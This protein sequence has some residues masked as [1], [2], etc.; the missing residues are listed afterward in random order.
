MNTPGTPLFVA[1]I[2]NDIWALNVI[3][4]VHNNSP[5]ETINTMVLAQYPNASNL[6]VVAR[7]LTVPPYAYFQNGKSVFI[8]MAGASTFQAALTAIFSDFQIGNQQ[9][10]INSV[11]PAA[12]LAMQSMIDQGLSNLL[13]G[14]ASGTFYGYS[15][16]GAAM[17]AFAQN[18]AASGNTIPISV[19]TYG[20]PKPFYTSFNGSLGITYTNWEN[21][22]DP[23][24][25]FPPN[26]A[27]YDYWLANTTMQQRFDAFPIYNVLNQW[28]FNHFGKLGG[29][30]VLQAGE[31][32]TSYSTAQLN[33]TQQVMV[34]LIVAIS[35][36][37][38][39]WNMN[40]TAEVTALTTQ[41]TI[42][43]YLN[44]L[45]ALLNA[46]ITIVANIPS[47][48]NITAPLSYILQ[49]S[50]N[51]GG[52]QMAPAA[53]YQITHF[54]R[55]GNKGWSHSAYSNASSLNLAMVHSNA[56]GSAMSSCFGHTD[57]GNSA[58]RGN[59]VITFVRIKPVNI[60]GATQL[61]E[62]DPD[63]YAHG[64]FPTIDVGAEPPVVALYNKIVVP[65]GSGRASRTE[66]LHGVPD[67]LIND[68][69]YTLTPTV[70][71]E[72]LPAYQQFIANINAYFLF[73]QRGG[74]TPGITTPWMQVLA[75]DPAAPTGA[76]QA[77]TYAA[78]YWNI[79]LTN[80]GASSG[81][82]TFLS[83][84]DR[85]VIERCNNKSFNGSWKISAVNGNVIT[86]ATGPLQGAQPP[87]T[88][89][90]RKSFDFNTQ[91]V[92]KVFIPYTNAISWTEY[93]QV[94]AVYE[95]RSRRVT[96]PFSNTRSAKKRKP[97][98][99]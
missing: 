64:P 16:G 56:L 68:E 81:G 48:V 51:L 8:L 20:S 74:T 23:V 14:A 52:P 24:P 77:G 71:G 3:Q 75:A 29:D 30:A 89:L 15:I 31:V 2:N 39:I 26:N 13:A 63:D 61:H 95:V 4:G 82:Y 62:V 70:P 47:S 25:L 97:E 41:H 57:S 53:G 22:N 10:A 36:F 94:G 27:F 86:L 78:D 11:L 34:N 9:W 60:V 17:S 37:Q 79:T 6:T 69:I 32:S 54:C 7:T 65:N 42:A 45:Y 21:V 73:L 87:S 91:K 35:S 92:C 99:N 40:Q 96:T 55:D 46:Q 88:G 76:V 59:P 67:E 80:A 58:N 28:L 38:A 90:W 49:S 84:N 1:Q 72:D 98:R 44:A 12:G 50:L 43:S 66:Y 18:T 93:S 85:I 19:T 33:A 83:P 5:F